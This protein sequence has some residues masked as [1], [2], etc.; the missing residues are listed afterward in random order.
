MV[1]DSL[2]KH[3]IAWNMKHIFLA[4]NFENQ[5]REWDVM[6]IVCSGNQS[7]HYINGRLVNCGKMLRFQSERA[8]V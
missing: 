3:E 8:E 5:I 1:I 6:E 2:D 4:K 7:E